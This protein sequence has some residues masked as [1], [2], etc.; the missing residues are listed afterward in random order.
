MERASVLNSQNLDSSHK[1]TTTILDKAG[2]VL[3]GFWGAG[4]HCSP[5]CKGDGFV[6]KLYFAVGTCNSRCRN[7]SS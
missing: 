6:M 2:N 4:M 3:K 1:R 5:T 7:L